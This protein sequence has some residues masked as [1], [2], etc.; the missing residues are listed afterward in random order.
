MKKNTFLIIDFDSTFVT[1]E[2]L[3]ELAKIALQGNPRSDSI[4]KQIEHIT[5]LGMEGKLQ[6]PKS[7]EK[8]LALFAPTRDH[9]ELLIQKLRKNITLSI[10]KNKEYFKQHKDQVYIVSGGFEEYIIL[11]IQ[12]FGI[13]KTHVLANAFIFDKKGRVIGFDKAKPLAQENGKVK[14]IQQLKLRGDIVVIGDGYTDYMVKKEG[15]ANT[16]IA[17]TENVYRESVVEK[18]DTAV[19]SFD[20]VISL[21]SSS[22]VIPAKAGNQ[23][24]HH[25]FVLPAPRSKQVE[26][27]KGFEIRV[28]KPKV[29]LLENINANAVI[30]FEKKGFSVELLLHALSEEELIEKIQDIT[31]LGIRSKTKV[32]QNVLNHAPKLKA[33]GAYCIGTDQIEFAAC[34]DQN[35]AVFN[36]PYSN[37]RSVAE[38]VIGEIIMLTRRVFE[39]SISLHNGVW[40]K[41][42]A[43]CFEV[44]GKKLGIVGYGNIGKQVSVLAEALG[45][46]VFYYDPNDTIYF[47]N[48]KRCKT[49]KQLL[50]IVD[51]VTI[52]VDGRKENRNLI[53]KKEFAQMK[54]GVVFL[55]LS[56]GF[57]VDLSALAQAVKTGN[58]AG[59]AIDVFPHEPASK[60]E[61]FEC[62]LQGL[63]NVI[64][65]PHVGGST[66]E[67]QEDIAV[68]VTKKL[69]DYIQLDAKRLLTKRSTYYE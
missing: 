7:L 32:T 65:T 63:P 43:G 60:N 18:A 55:N 46:Y 11:I 23:I 3:E 68:Y 26:N 67:A 51:I 58:V 5:K 35:I 28:Q 50:S 19:K 13:D 62:V 52:H 53:G 42:A 41:S 21:L 25:H 66:Q 30:A 4:I 44:R 10:Q 1:V 2:G 49:L 34:K 33:I 45:M 9:I 29:L 16:F 20:E 38:L 39:K 54:K 48:A 22:L 24:P 69:T 36:A 17:F 59:A 12:E 6:S 64:L 37:T 8:R 61:P 56:R 40:D 14:A 27:D 57:I 47:N 31:L 15:I